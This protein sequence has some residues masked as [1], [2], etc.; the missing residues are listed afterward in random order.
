MN[1]IIADRYGIPELDHITSFYA[2]QRYVASST[3]IKRNFGFVFHKPG[4]EHDPKEFTQCV[5]P[6]LPW[7]P[8][9]IITGR[10]STPTCCKRPSNTAA[11]SVRGRA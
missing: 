3:G 6:E 10:T 4:E 8:R 7:G 2:T 9:A 11:R 5:I 1:R